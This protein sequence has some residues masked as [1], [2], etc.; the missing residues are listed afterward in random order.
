MK[1]Y[2]YILVGVLLAWSCTDLSEY[3][4]DI[5]DVKDQIEQVRKEC[6]KINERMESMQS[7][8]AQVQ[9]RESITGISEILDDDGNVTGYVITFKNAETITFDLPADDLPSV[10]IPEEVFISI[11]MDN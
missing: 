3:E 6:D 9:A 2:L 8:A 1:R 7:L 4:D 11:K 5:E 10:E